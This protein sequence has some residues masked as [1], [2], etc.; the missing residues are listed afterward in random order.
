MIAIGGRAETFLILTFLH[1]LILVALTLLLEGAIGA[2]RE[3]LTRVNLN[4]TTNIAHT[5]LNAVDH[6]TNH[7]LIRHMVGPLE[8]TT[9]LL[10]STCQYL[11]S[12]RTQT[13]HA[14]GSKPHTIIAQAAT[15]PLVDL[16]H[17]IKQGRRMTP[18]AAIADVA[19]VAPLMADPIEAPTLRLGTR[20]AAPTMMNKL[21]EKPT[22]P[23]L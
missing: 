21:R 22:W 20:A 5:H 18:T 3:H 7:R 12:V 11:T 19:V 14:V 16:L 4:I 8:A 13:N 1:D 23:T 10:H 15:T 6:S 17:T 2:A 9:N